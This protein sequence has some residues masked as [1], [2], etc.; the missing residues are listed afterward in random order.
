MNIGIISS[1]TSIRGESN[2]LS[3]NIYV[4]GPQVEDGAFATRY[5]PTTS[6]V[7][8]RAADVYTPRPAWDVTPV[9]DLADTDL[10]IKFSIWREGGK[11]GIGSGYNVPLTWPF[12]LTRDK[13]MRCVFV[14]ETAGGT[15][16][17]AMVKNKVALLANGVDT[18]IEPPNDAEPRL[19]IF[20]RKWKS[21][22]ASK[23]DAH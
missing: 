10:Q 13:K 20:K 9:E 2:A 14:V 3:T 21:V 12:A 18:A 15:S 16:Q 1:A 4:A 8:T 6:S 23:F 5:I 17:F 22:H 7:A 19:G 11:L